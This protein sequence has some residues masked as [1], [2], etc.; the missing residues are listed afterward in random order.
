VSDVDSWALAFQN[1]LEAS[2]P[3]DLEKQRLG[4]EEM[5]GNLS[6]FFWS[7]RGAKYLYSLRFSGAEPV[8]DEPLPPISA[9]SHELRHVRMT[10][11]KE[12]TEALHRIYH[13]TDS[14]P[15]AQNEQFVGAFS[16]EYG[17]WETNGVIRWELYR[18]L[19]LAMICVLV[20][21][22]VLIADVLASFYVLL[23]VLVTLV[24]NSVTFSSDGDIKMQIR[25]ACGRRC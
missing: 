10:R 5:M 13:L 4:E 2:H 11:T 3:I 8:C 7:P 12:K 17:T 9:S 16:R 19:G 24:R 23:C 15:L 18:N 25:G 20:T 6:D 22:L 21:V 1:W 14:S